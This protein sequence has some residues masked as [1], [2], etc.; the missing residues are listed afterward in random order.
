MQGI[1][2]IC[3]VF[4]GKSTR[5]TLSPDPVVVW[6]LFFFWVPD[7]VLSVLEKKSSH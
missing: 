6:L 3:P 2:T 5:L 7:M 4:K 1:L